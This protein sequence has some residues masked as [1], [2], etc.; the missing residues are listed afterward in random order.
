MILWLVLDNLL[1]NRELLRLHAKNKRIRCVSF[2]KEINLFQPI[3][4]TLERCDVIQKCAHVL[5][6][7]RL[8]YNADVRVHK[9]CTVL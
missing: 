6:T 2:C 3:T 5:I 1:L 4:L 8:R 7:V 9:L